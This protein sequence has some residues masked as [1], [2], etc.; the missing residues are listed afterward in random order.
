MAKRYY[1]VVEVKTGEAMDFLILDKE[2][3][4]E[5]V[6]IIMNLGDEF[7][8]R[9]VT[10][11]DNLV[12][13]LADWYNFYRSESISLERIGSVG[14]DSGMLMITD[15][16][17]VKEATDEKCEEI[18]EATKEEGAAQ[19]LNSYALGFNTAYGDGI[20]DVYAKKDENGRI[21]K[22]EIVME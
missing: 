21:I 11:T 4:P 10:K 22:V 13:K 3:C 2:Q 18:Y 19:I 20:Y 17:Y 7:E 8:L 14:V 1:E 9:R 6:A 5:R 15:P 12:E 16:C